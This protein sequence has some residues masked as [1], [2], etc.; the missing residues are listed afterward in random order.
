MA[1]A[2]AGAPSPAQAAIPAKPNLIFILADDYGLGEVSCYGADHYQTPNLDRLAREG[3]R[4]THAY[5]PSL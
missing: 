1:F 3:T 5:T 4:F 2:A